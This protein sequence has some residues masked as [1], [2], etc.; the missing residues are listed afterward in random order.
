MSVRKFAKRPR[1]ETDGESADAGGAFF[2]MGLKTKKVPMRMHADNRQR[3]VDRMKAVGA[4]G[5]ILLK[6]G[7]QEFR[8]DTDT[9]RVFRQESYFN[10]AFGVKEPEFL[11]A[12]DIDTG[13]TTLLMPRLSPNDQAWVGP[14]V[15]A[16]Q[17][18]AWYE[19][20]EVIYADEVAAFA[21]RAGKTIHILHGRNT[22]SGSQTV[23]TA[24]F[25]GIESHTVDRR[26]L[27]HQFADCRVYKSTAELELL[28]HVSRVSSEAHVDVMRA[29]KPGMAEY[30]LEALFCYHIYDRAGCRSPAYTC[31]CACGPNAGT[32]HYGHAGAPNS[33]IL[34]ETD[35][36]LL[37]MGAEYH[38]YCSD[39]T[40]SFPVSGKFTKDQKLIYTGVLMAVKAVEE[41]MKPGVS[42]VDMHRLATRSILE[43]LKGAGVLE[44]DVA[45]MVAVNLGATFLPC[46][47]GHFIG[48]D[49]HDVGGYLEGNPER[50][51]EGPHGIKKL[52]TARIL[53]EGMV[54]TV[55]PGI[56]FVDHLLDLALATPAKAV[57]INE[58]RLED[59]RGFGGVRLEDVVAVTATGIDNYTLTPRTV[60]EIESVMAGGEWPPAT[61]NALWMCRRW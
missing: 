9:E 48:C 16:E 17:F 14:L 51:D 36:A 50:I 23:T 22:D 12:I 10:W 59:F 60:E 2:S 57:F 11:G 49:T 13:K 20:D 56:Y 25:D 27:F 29:I 45:D 28:A 21:A 26:T 5:L 34:K 39:I 53:E 61:D 35:I 31:I 37:D 38:A 6:S 7:V 58:D 18:K 19:V 1:V 8:H 40:C 44:G 41:A 42:W 47:L 32:L 54:L 30:Q 43:H 46:G 3:L 52:R 33:R 55:E 24:T 15:T 4:T